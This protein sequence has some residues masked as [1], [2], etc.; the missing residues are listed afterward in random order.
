M[1]RVATDV[2][3][4]R[5]DTKAADRPGEIVTSGGSPS[6]ASGTIS[7]DTLI[8]R[9]VLDSLGTAHSI[10]TK[11]L[12]REPLSDEEETLA[13]C[14]LQSTYPQQIEIE[15][16]SRL[17]KIDMLFN[18]FMN[19]EAHEKLK[20]EL[21]E[22]IRLTKIYNKTAHSWTEKFLLS[23]QQ[24][25]SLQKEVIYAGQ[26]FGYL[27]QICGDV[28][29][30]RSEI[31]W[32]KKPRGELEN[33]AE[34]QQPLVLE[35]DMVAALLDHA[36]RYIKSHIEY[37]EVSRCNIE[38]YIAQTQEF[39]NDPENSLPEPDIIDRGAGMLLNT[40]PSVLGGLITGRLIC[41]E[42]RAY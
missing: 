1:M 20:E 7:G 19:R 8:E 25:A 21:A 32:L 10:G 27:H 33:T 41:Q 29:C 23:K 36:E 39:L 15:N 37:L 26:L 2:S 28:P 12:G 40:F 17:D 13:L 6:Q 3:L 30:I 16:A 11:F 9:E 24:K 22:A 5:I 14:M 34:Y 4:P 18:A 42:Q 31:D 38:E 35:E